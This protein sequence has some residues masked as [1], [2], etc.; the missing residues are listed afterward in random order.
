[1]FPEKGP[2]LLNIIKTIKTYFLTI[3]MFAGQFDPHFFHSKAPVQ[4]QIKDCFFF[5]CMLLFWYFTILERG[6]LAFLIFS[7]EK[8]LKV[9]Y[10]FYFQSI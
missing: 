7:A 3:L 5:G 4:T 1:M 9:S 8:D 10:D 6:K 2:D